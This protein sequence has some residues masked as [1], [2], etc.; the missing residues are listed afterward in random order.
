MKI[1][2]V[3]APSQYV[4]PSGVGTIK[5]TYS[6][7]QSQPTT[8]IQYAATAPKVHNFLRIIYLKKKN[9]NKYSRPQ[10]A[11]SQTP[12]PQYQV[13]YATQPNPYSYAPYGI[14]SPYTTSAYTTPNAYGTGPIA[15]ASL[16]QGQIIPYTTAAN[17]LFLNPTNLQQFYN[18][19]AYP[20]SLNA[21]ATV[22]PLTAYTT[23]TPIIP[24]IGSTVVSPTTAAYYSAAPA[25]QTYQQS[26]A[27]R[28]FF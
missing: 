24:K 12:N 23:A 11:Y 21:A 17:S 13:A 3:R 19:F 10:L 7:D 15:A 8:T 26:P 20:Q 28:K 2:Y 5:L 16:Q 25:S 1:F 4:A 18:S 27:F 9:E 14:A 6:P 22:Q